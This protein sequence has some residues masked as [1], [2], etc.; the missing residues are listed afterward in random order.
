MSTTATDGWMFSENTESSKA[1]TAILRLEGIRS[2]EILDD[3][4][5]PD[6]LP[7]DRTDGFVENV[8]PATRSTSAKPGSSE[9]VAV[10]AQ[11]YADGEELWHPSD[12]RDVV[13]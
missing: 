3:K 10:L 12:A 2:A 6:Y 11:R 7:G 4:M 9:K 5:L 8:K 13:R 1:F